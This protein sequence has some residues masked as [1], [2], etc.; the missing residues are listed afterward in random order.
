MAVRK[1]SV[2]DKF[3]RRDELAL[4]DKRIS[5]TDK[6][7]TIAAWNESELWTLEGRLAPIELKAQEILADSE[8]LEPYFRHYADEALRLIGLTRFGAEKGNADAAARSALEL[9]AVWREFELKVA[10]EKRTFAS[11]EGGK[12][13]AERRWPGEHRKG[14][15]AHIKAE[16]DSAR[17]RG[18]PIM[19][20]YDALAQKYGIPD[21]TLRRLIT[22]K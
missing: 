17:S 18:V 10:F 15:R 19:Q 14:E 1:R 12:K 2:G 9:G 13:G 7:D 21:R 22:G 16:F 4:F 6:R 5:I 3:S 8:K 20:A 11:S